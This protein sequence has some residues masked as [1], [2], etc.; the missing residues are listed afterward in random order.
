MTYAFR[1]GSAGDAVL[2][3]DGRYRYLLARRWQEGVGHART[4]LWIML[5]P[6]SADHDRDD[7]TVRKCI[8][9]SKAWGA[10]ALK[11]VNLFAYRTSNPQDLLEVMNPVGPANQEHVRKAGDDCD[12]VIVAWGA[13]SNKLWY[14]SAAIRTA[15]RGE[16]AGKLQCL[17]RTR[18]GAPRHP[19]RIGYVTALEDWK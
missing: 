10:S 15:V 17:G 7:L 14:A 19:S 11:V 16:Y 1:S 8:G 6:S 4:I 2:S 5:N 13:L 3:H 9:F 18:T 12:K